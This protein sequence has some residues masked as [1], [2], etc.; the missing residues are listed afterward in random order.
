M[1]ICIYLQV[2]SL[3]FKMSLNETLFLR[4]PG[5]MVPGGRLTIL[6][7]KYVTCP[8]HLAVDLLHRLP[9][10]KQRAREKM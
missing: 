6:S 8:R 4:V 3:H 1:S 7:G 10:G 9:D 2:S 5:G